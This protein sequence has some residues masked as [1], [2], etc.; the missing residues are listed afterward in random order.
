MNQSKQGS[1]SATAVLERAREVKL[2][3]G[4]VP[5]GFLPTLIDISWERCLSYGLDRDQHG[6]C[7][8]LE[9]V[10]LAD[11]MEKNRHLLS[12]AQPVMNVLFEQIVDTQNVVVLANDAGYILHSCGDPEFLDR[13]EKVALAPGAE[14]SEVSR[15][16][17]AIGTAL[18]VGAPVVV[19]GDQHF[20]LANHSLTCSASPILPQAMGAGASNR[21]W[22]GEQ[23]GPKGASKCESTREA[24][25]P[26]NR[27]ALP[28]QGGRGG[29]RHAGVAHRSA[30]SMRPRARR[31]IQQG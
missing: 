25:M 19:N 12:H 22:R 29:G 23:R 10:R 27:L 30:G 18:A 3:L 14:W 24:D 9:R 31:D 28:A 13:A 7:D 16:T 4:T 26:R 6:E 17:N 20:L 11:Q 2:D 21:E 1:E 8:V 15:G 5:A